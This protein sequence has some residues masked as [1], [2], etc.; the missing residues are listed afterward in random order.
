MALGGESAKK[1]KRNVLPCLATDRRSM[2]DNNNTLLAET[3][4]H[5][6]MPFGYGR[7]NTVSSLLWGA[8]SLRRKR[9]FHTDVAPGLDPK[10]CETSIYFNQKR[11][12]SWRYVT[13]EAS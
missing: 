10:N 2:A 4:L 8:C 9:P 1:D 12:V 6:S 13:H 5:K 11:L 3:I 7:L